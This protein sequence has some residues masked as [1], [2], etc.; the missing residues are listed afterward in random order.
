MAEKDSESTLARASKQFSIIAQDLFSIEVNIILRNNISAQKMPNPRH[1]LLDIGKE[2]CAALEGMEMNRQE[3]NR[4]PNAKSLF[5]EEDMFEMMR[6]DLGFMTGDEFD[7]RQR[8]KSV[9][10][11]V[12]EDKVVSHNVGSELGGFDAFDVLR[13]WADSLIDD[14]NK[15]K[16]LD[17]AQLAVLPRIK[18]NADLIKGMYSMLCRR[19]PILNAPNRPEGENLERLLEMR[20]AESRITPNTIVKL[21][22]LIDY[23][24][25]IDLTNE[26]SRSDLVNRDD[27]EPLQIRDSDLMSIR[28]I[29]ELGTEVIAMQTIVQIDGDVITRLNPNFLDETK[30]PRLYDYHNKGVN[31]ALAHWSTLVS[32]AKELIVATA[33]GISGSL[34]E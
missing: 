20:E 1:A 29:W 8:S 17:P 6:Q 24:R 26:Y 33:R 34:R 32:V 15:G 12:D 23:N 7:E 3:Y 4:D 10:D 16:F 2:Y 14:E 25:T 13:T 5:F 30:Y 18:D 31:I 19:D 11:E 27:I 28:K 22:K 21:S 9:F